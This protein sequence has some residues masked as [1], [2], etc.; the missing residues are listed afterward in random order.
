MNF[1]TNELSNAIDILSKIA[2]PLTKSGLADQQFCKIESKGSTATFS[3]SNYDICIS[4][5]I[6]FSGKAINLY[7]DVIA[8]RDILK[9][10]PKKCT[11]DITV[12]ND[13]IT[14]SSNDNKFTLNVPDCTIID[15]L[16]I[17][18]VKWNEIKYEKLYNITANY[19]EFIKK[20]ASVCVSKNDFRLQMTG[21]CLSNQSGRLEIASTDTYRLIRNITN[22]KTKEETPEIIIPLTYIPMI[23]IADYQVSRGYTIKEV[24]KTDEVIQ[25]KKYNIVCMQNSDTIIYFNPIND[26]FVPYQSVIPKTYESKSLINVKQFGELVKKATMLDKINNGGSYSTCSQIIFKVL[27]TDKGKLKP[28]FDVYVKDEKENDVSVGKLFCLHNVNDDFALNFK[29]LGDLIKCMH[30]EN[31]KMLMTQNDKPILFQ[32]DS[33]TMLIMPVRLK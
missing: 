8:L 3:I 21:V 12:T 10:F 25:E 32:N 23:E 16:L 20:D 14:I 19:I 1:K 24:K 28:N 7:I 33:V 2:I 30:A 9:M 5:K 13:V 11:T 27:K 6:P 4:K 15:N 17:N 31:I 26:K 22:I 29:Y 18:N